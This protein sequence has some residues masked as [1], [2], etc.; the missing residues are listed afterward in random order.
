MARKLRNIQA[1]EQEKVRLATDKLIGAPLAWWEAHCEIDPMAENMVWDD[2]VKLF[3]EHHIPQQVMT[4]KL[5]EFID[6]RQGNLTVGEYLEKFNELARYAPEEC[7][8]DAKKQF[9]FLC[10]LKPEL[11]TIVQATK[12][13]SF[14]DMYNAALTAEESK[15]EEAKERKRKFEGRTFQTEKTQRTQ[16]PAQSRQRAQSATTFRAPVSSFRQSSQNTRH[17]QSA[18][19][20]KTQVNSRPQQSGASQV[21]NPKACFNCRE[22]GHFIANCPYKR[23]STPSVYSNSVPAPGRQN[24]HGAPSRS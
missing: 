7:K 17:T 14:V 8:D 12:H 24:N 1:D 4:R 20:M 15:I 22:T 19:Q 5:Q 10:G 16:H 3:R 11:K 13:A 9:Y 6:I 18:P 2:F 21:T 23:Q